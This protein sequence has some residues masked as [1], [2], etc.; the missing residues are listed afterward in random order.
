MSHVNA[1]ALLVLGT[2][3]VVAAA[4]A[5]GLSAR[6]KPATEAGQP[7]GYALPD[8]RSH[9][10]DVTK[11]TLTVAGDK[12]AVTLVREDKGWVVKEKGGFPADTVK[13]R[14]LLIKLADASR[15]EA[16][17]ANEQ[18]Y[19]ELGI[20]AVTSKD[21]KGVQI[22]LDGL[23]EPA[24]LIVGKVNGEANGTFVR[25]PGDKQSW[26]VKGS[27]A[28]DRDPIDWLE[29]TLADIASD[30]VA[31]IDLTRPGARRL[32]LFKAK[33][34]DAAFVVADLP[35]DRELAP[36]A[37][38]NGLASTLSA[39]TLSDVSPDQALPPPDKGE[40]THLKA[41]YR[42]FDEV[43]VTIDA[44][45]QNG[46]HFARLAATLDT[47]RA[48]SH[49][50]SAQAQAKADYEAAQKPTGSGADQAKVQSPPSPP[51]V[52]DPTKDRQQ[53][54]DELNR[55]VGGLSQ[56]FNGWTFIIPEQSYA[57]LDTSLE[58]LLK[59]KGNAKGAGQ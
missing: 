7:S 38:L 52:A 24:R 58:S 42:T 18:R 28:V 14:E 37:D 31:E 35:K 30:R 11:V 43:T 22:G 49:I 23:P 10:N 26:L 8:L 9:L 40:G 16:K 34:S 54:L 15:V 5:F 59:P 45:K 46:R 33:P 13:L 47:S 19:P 1:K 39:L 36:G 55:E 48:E 44:W 21:A 32:H 27:L 25:S 56:R 51:A 53:R 17:T 41:R 12:L 57:K 6:R 20:E 3:A 29:K 50:Q 2:A 4:A